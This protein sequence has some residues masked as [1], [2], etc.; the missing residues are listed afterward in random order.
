M[1]R[2][3]SPPAAMSQRSAMLD[4]IR[5]VAILSVFAFHVATRYDPVALDPVAAFLQ[6]TGFLGVDIFFP[7]SGYLISRFLLTSQRPDFIK[8][9]FLRRA[10][11]ILPL[12]FLALFLFFIANRLVGVGADVIDRLWINGLFLTG[13]YVFFEGK[14]SVPYLITWSL[15]VEE[16]GYILL[17]LMALVQ[18]RAMVPFLVVLA[19]G[20]ILLRYAILLDSPTRETFQALYYLPVARLDSIAFGG[21]TAHLMLRRSRWLVPGL[22]V[23]GAIMLGLMMQDLLLYRTLLFIFIAVVTCLC[24]VAAETILRDW[25]GPVVRLFATIGFYSYFN[26]LFQFFVIDAFLL[27]AGKV[28]LGGMNYWLVFAIT[29]AVTQVLAVLSNRLFEGPLMAFGRRLEH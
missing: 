8:V 16:F 4:C 24:I 6:K 25:R 27:V 11:R 7:L 18:R 1:I 17:G 3:F 13:W 12:Y 19:I 28:G 23:T 15:S 26:Y 22:V 10:F 2:F 9:F 5:A 14:D 21:L 20:P 29:L